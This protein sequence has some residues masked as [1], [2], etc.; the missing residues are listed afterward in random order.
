MPAPH[1]RSRSVGGAWGDKV[2]DRAGSL[3]R[4]ASP[5][6]WAVRGEVAILPTGASDAAPRQPCMNAEDGVHYR[7]ETACALAELVRPLPCTDTGHERDRLLWAFLLRSIQPQLYIHACTALCC[8]HKRAA[9]RFFFPRK[10]QAQQ[11][12]DENTNRLALQRRHAPD[13]QFVTPRNLELAAFSPG[14]VN[15]AS[16]SPGTTWRP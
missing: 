16:P 4:T 1:C 9:C 3:P 12:Y 5:V 14:T 10:E 2:P 11:Q 8:L 7:T 15:A 6:R 13:D